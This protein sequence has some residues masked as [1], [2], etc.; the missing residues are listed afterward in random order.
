MTE[1]TNDFD[2]IDDIDEIEFFK[3][4]VEKI[5]FI[6]E[7]TKPNKAAYSDEFEIQLDKTRKFIKTKY[8]KYYLIF[9]QKE[10]E[11]KI[12]N[13][14]S[15]FSL[16]I[17]LFEINLTSI[18]FK[19]D[20]FFDK[21]IFQNKI[22][23]N[24]V[25]FKKQIDFNQCLFMEMVE[26]YNVKFIEKSFF[27]NLS[28]RNG[29]NFLYCHFSESVDMAYSIFINIINFDRSHFERELFFKGS[30]FLGTLSFSSEVYLINFDNISFDNDDF[31][32][33]LEG[34]R[35]KNLTHHESIESRRNKDKVLKKRNPDLVEGLINLDFKNAEN[36]ETF[37]VLK[38]LFIKMNDTISALEFHKKE[39]EKY[40]SDLNW[41]KNFE[42]KFLLFF[43][44]Y[45]SHFGTSTLGALISF[46]LFNIICFLIYLYFDYK[47]FF[48][49]FVNDLINNVNCF[50]AS[51]TSL[52]LRIFP[53]FYL[54]INSFLTYEI[55][56]SF[57][58]FSRK[59]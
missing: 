43:E 14:E 52:N 1:E 53:V 47:L 25:V 3:D 56:K 26:F 55:I 49:S 42:D 40:Y 37:L 22:Y 10:F 39:Y 5:K 29:V 58:K 32:L 19:N 51:T 4:P 6:Y 50:L 28:F 2:D 30:L 11:N 13:E 20:I 8:G 48:F 7:A 24:D 12:K 9:N 57:R 41:N 16:H 23:F 15:D 21:S 36:R 38:K 54:I 35:I 18:E 31:I 33:S 59:L 34:S 27:F 17:F 44:N 45:I 46:F